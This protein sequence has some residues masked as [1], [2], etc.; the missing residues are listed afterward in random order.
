[1][2]STTRLSSKG[3]VVI[4][5][6]VRRL[7]NLR[8]GEE[9]QVVASAAE[10]AILLR[11]PGPGDVERKLARGYEWLERSGEDPVAALHEARRQA[12]KQERRRR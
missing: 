6:A 4:P 5:A 9:L 2:A 12:R 1:M 3:Q 11:G 8:P 7:L 10:R